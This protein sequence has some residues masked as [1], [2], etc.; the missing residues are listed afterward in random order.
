IRWFMSHFKFYSA[1]FEANSENGVLSLQGKTHKTLWE[2]FGN[3]PI[4]N[5]DEIE[6]DFHL[7][8]KGT[9]RFIIWHWFD[10]Q[11][12]HGVISLIEKGVA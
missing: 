11:L 4:N 12:E 8:G 2:E 7:W 3:T 10:D 9:D 1:W 5:D 6:E